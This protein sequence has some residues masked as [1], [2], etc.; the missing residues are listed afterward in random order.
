M[1][2]GPTGPLLF[3]IDIANK[4]YDRAQRTHMGTTQNTLDHMTY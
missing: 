3:S 2:G 4:A 1:T